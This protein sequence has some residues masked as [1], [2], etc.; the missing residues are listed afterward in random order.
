MLINSTLTTI[1]ANN[2]NDT[3]QLFVITLG[4]IKQV[5]KN[6][7]NA[8]LACEGQVEVGYFVRNYFNGILIK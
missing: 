2:E 6:F 7:Y 5:A 4:A 1:Q 8:Q 3:T